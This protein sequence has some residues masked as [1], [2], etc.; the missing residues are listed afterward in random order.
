M[1][2]LL[3]ISSFAFGCIGVHAQIS[4]DPSIPANYAPTTVLFPPS[5]LKYQILFVG[6][7]DSVKTTPTYGNPASTVPAKQW[8]DFIGVTPDNNNPSEFWISVNHEMRQK[9][10]FIGDGGGMT[11]FKVRRDPNTDTLVVINQTLS[12]GRSGKFF[13]VDFVNT[14]GETGMNCA[15]LQGVDGRIWTAEEWQVV[16]NAQAFTFLPDTNDI[17]LNTPEFPTFNGKKIKRFQGLNW[18][19]EI[20]PKEAKAIRKQYNWGRLFLEGGAMAGDNRT[21]YLGEDSSPGLFVKFVADVPGDFTKGKTYYYAHTQ[22]PKWVE[23]DNTDLDKMLNLNALALAGGATVF[24]RLEWSA[25]DYTTGRLYLTETGR[26]DLGKASSWRAAINGSAKPAQHHVARAASKG[27]TPISDNY[28]DYYGRVLCYD[29]VT[30]EV[31]VYLEGG[32]EFTEQQVPASNYPEKHLSNPDGLNFMTIGGKVYMIINEDL[33]GRTFGRMPNS[34]TVVCEAFL[35]DMSIPNPTV[36]NLIRF[37]A[38][39]LDAEI[40]GACMSPDGKT[41][42]INSQH[43][44]TTLNEGIYRNSLTYAITGWDKITVSALEPTFESGPRFQVWPN[45]VSRELNFNKLTDAALYDMNG[46]LIRVFRNTQVADMSGCTPGIY[47][48][49]NLEG[50]TIKIV[51]Q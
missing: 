35:L 22:N 32:P 9:N 11:S 20:D 18:M 30:E 23:V 48:V 10:A 2:K 4:F 27:L 33:N 45:P 15:G 46:K 5:P 34:S 40:T 12:D 7:V 37:S 3:L 43:P 41:M 19:V 13:N 42:L 51:V 21:V 29:P 26:D 17:T 36:D 44:S 14:T 16:N 24:N 49:R 8:H 25:V 47:F 6:Q 28:V 50:E 31:T 38:T 39:P 1:K